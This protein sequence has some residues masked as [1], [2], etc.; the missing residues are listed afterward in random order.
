MT[1]EPKDMNEK[2]EQA[3]ELALAGMSDMEIARRVKVS[4]Q[5]V[6]HWRN[7]DEAFREALAARRQTLREQNIDRL[8]ELVEEAIAAARE[9]LRSQNENTRLK[10]AALILKVSGMQSGMKGEKLADG[11]RAE[12]LRELGSAIGEVAREL[13]FRDP[14]EPDE[15]KQ[16]GNGG[17]N[18]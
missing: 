2:Q 1:N 5:W 7:Q 15:P 17:L 9:A 16:L 10:A 4:R 14:T 12:F 3:L 11:G 8:N 18:N 13:G 6:N